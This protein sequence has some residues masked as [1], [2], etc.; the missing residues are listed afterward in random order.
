MNVDTIMKKECGKWQSYQRR[1]C[2]HCGR[3][4]AQPLEEIVLPGTWKV[5]GGRMVW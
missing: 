5:A 3:H 4:L 1:K 2:I